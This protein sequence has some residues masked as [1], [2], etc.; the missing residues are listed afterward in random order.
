MMGLVL[1]PNLLQL[2][3]C[4]ELVGLC[5]YLLI[6]FWYQKPEAARARGQGLLDDEGRRRRPAD[7][8]RPAVAA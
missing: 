2:F 7:R 6:G 3:I 4:W 1:A 8:H 5:S